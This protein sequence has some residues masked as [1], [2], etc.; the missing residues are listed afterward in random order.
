MQNECLMLGSIDSS[1][2]YMCMSVCTHD[3][4]WHF[5]F[6]FLKVNTRF[7]KTLGSWT[8]IYQSWRARICV[9]SR[10][11]LVWFHKFTG[12]SSLGNSHLSHGY[13]I[14]WPPKRV[15]LIWPPFIKGIL[16]VQHWQKSDFSGWALTGSMRE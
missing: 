8:S 16:Q 9:D 10:L 4:Y 7:F 15:F 1:S 2:M 14:H 6:I 11:H 3:A 5:F 12:H 13:T